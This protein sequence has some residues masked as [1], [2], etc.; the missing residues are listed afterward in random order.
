M[1]L[2]IMLIVT[3][4]LSQIIRD[5]NLLYI[6]GIQYNNIFIGVVIVLRNSIVVVGELLQS[7]PQLRS[8][9]CS[10]IVLV[11]RSRVRSP[12]GVHCITIGMRQFKLSDFLCLLI[13]LSS[14]ARID[15]A[16][17][18][19]PL[20][21]SVTRAVANR[22]LHQLEHQRIAVH[23]TPFA[24]VVLESP[25]N[26]FLHR[27]MRIIQD[28]SQITLIARLFILLQAFIRAHLFH[29]IR[30]LSKRVF[31]FGVDLKLLQLG[32]NGSS[33]IFPLVVI[34]QK[35]PHHQISTIARALRT[36]IIML[37]D[38]INR[39]RRRVTCKR[40]LQFLQ[41]SL[42]LHLVS[43]LLLLVRFQ[44][45]SILCLLLNHRNVA[46]FFAQFTNITKS[47]QLQLFLRR[48][49]RTRNRTSNS[50]RRRSYSR[51]L[52]TT[53]STRRV[54]RSVCLSALVCCVLYNIIRPFTSSDLNVS[55]NLHLLQQCLA[56]TIVIMPR[57]IILSPLPHEFQLRLIIVRLSIT[58]VL[59]P[60]L[61]CPH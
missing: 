60:I 5:N 18:V 57:A 43:Q 12:V 6:V 31:E 32:C 53:T 58:I 34:L 22:Q 17:H 30:E 55:T 36:I 52:V 25:H 7:K 47:A 21:T 29:S 9:R 48:L 46:Q 42:V 28:T 40:L 13:A 54:R 2:R 16:N 56:T 4:Q 8:R 51:L 41:L 11:A 19:R 38:I 49:L 14:S 39:N 33:Q 24:F 10:L 61:V 44:F 23:R 37:D 50:C 26:T 45:Q 59:V 27:W 1:P 3:V 35:L 20:S 15:F